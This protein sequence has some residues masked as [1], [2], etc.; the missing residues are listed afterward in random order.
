MVA[1]PA[2]LRR[3]EAPGRSDGQLRFRVHIRT[4]FQGALV[5]PGGEGMGDFSAQPCRGGYSVLQTPI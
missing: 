2:V 4:G 5:A 1:D 3:F